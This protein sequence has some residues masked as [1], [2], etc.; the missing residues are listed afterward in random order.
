MYVTVT[1]TVNVCYSYCMLHLILCLVL[2]CSILLRC[3]VSVR[4]REDGQS[5]GTA[6]TGA[7]CFVKMELGHRLCVIQ[8]VCLQQ[9]DSPQRNRLTVRSATDWQS[10]G[11]Q[12]DS[13]QGDRLT[14]RRA[15]DWQSAGRQTDSPQGDRLTVCYQ[16]A[17]R[18]WPQRF[19][20][21]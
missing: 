7:H 12:T 9:T 18:N 21:I 4:I 10:A 2:F 19:D 1:V 14:V 15:T 5:K 6:V 20:G 16:R 13:P 3:A 17:V 8:L 11:R